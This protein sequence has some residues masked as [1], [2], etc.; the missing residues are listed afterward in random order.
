[1]NMGILCLFW[2]NESKYIQ[3]LDRWFDKTHFKCITVSDGQSGAWR[4]DL[5]EP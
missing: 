4:N 1:M 2:K 5:N 3:G